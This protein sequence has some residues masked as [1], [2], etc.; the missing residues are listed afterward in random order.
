VEAPA[1]LV[2]G[3][4]QGEVLSALLL[5]REVPWNKAT[6]DEAV[7][8]TNGSPLPSFE[9]EGGMKLTVLGPTPTELSNLQVV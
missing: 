6:N 2:F 7:C 5:D 4:E 9:L 1:T 8:R 3:P